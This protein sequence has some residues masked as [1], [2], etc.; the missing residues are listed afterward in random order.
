MTI[1]LSNIGI[2]STPVA[3]A[4]GAQKSTFFK[5]GYSRNP[6]SPELLEND[7]NQAGTSALLGLMNKDL[8]GSIPTRKVTGLNSELESGKSILAGI[9]AGKAYQDP[10]TSPYYQGVRNE[11]ATQKEKGAS[12]IRRQSQTGGM[13]RSS[14]ALRAEGDYR[15]DMDDQASTLLGQLAESE[16]NRDNDYTR[17]DAASKFGEQ[18]R[19]IENEQNNATYESELM[20]VLAPFQYQLPIATQMSEYGNYW[21]P[22]FD[23][24]ASGLENTTAILSALAPFVVPFLGKG[25]GGGGSSGAYGAAGIG[26]G[27]DIASTILGGL[28]K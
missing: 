27:S 8:S 10:A 2:R 7:Y 25:G 5:R 13:L 24:Q 18:L 19:T 17:L 20:K 6:S 4:S 9:M 11:L 28:F 21:M 14:G 15:K 1:N 22:Q 16:R 26:A 12:A 23:Q 3:G